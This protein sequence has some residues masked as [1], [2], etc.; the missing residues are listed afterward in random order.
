MGSELDRQRSALES[1]DRK[2]DQANTKTGKVNSILNKILR[3]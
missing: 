3:K 1:L 2:M